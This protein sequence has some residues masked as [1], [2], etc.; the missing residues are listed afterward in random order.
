[1]QPNGFPIPLTL[2]ISFV[3]SG[4]LISHWI[5]VLEKRHSR[6][7]RLWI[8]YGGLLIVPLMMLLCYC[9]VRHSL[10]GL[11]SFIFVISTCWWVFI[12]VVISARHGPK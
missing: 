9:F 10:I 12:N 2:L 5:P 6:S 7:Q 3:V 1:M 8:G 4:F 11:C